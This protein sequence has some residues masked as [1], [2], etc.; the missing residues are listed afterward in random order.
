MITVKELQLNILPSFTEL[1]AGEEGLNREVSWVVVSRPRPPAFEALKGGEIALVSL[2]SLRLLDE[3]IDLARL[4]TYL[5]EM[6][7]VAVAVL[8]N[9]GPEAISVADELSLPVFSLPEGTSLSELNSNISR[10]IADNRQQLQQWNQEVYRQFTELAIEGKGIAAIAEKLCQLTGKEVI[11]ED[12][13]FR[14]RAHYAPAVVDAS[15]IRSRSNLNSLGGLSSRLDRSDNRSYS[16]GNGKFA[17]SNGSAES[18]TATV[19]LSLENEESNKSNFNSVLREKVGSL[20]DWLHNKELRSS[21]PPLHVFDVANGL[22]QLVAPIIVQSEVSGYVSLLGRDFTMPQRVAISRAAAALAIERAREIAVSA[23][24]DR[25]QANVIDELLD[26]NFSNAESVVERAKRL[27]Y[28]LELPYYVVAFAFR[29]ET[30]RTR[31]KPMPIIVGGQ[32][33]ELEPPINESMSRELQRLVEQEAN[34]R[35]ITTITRVR[36]DRFVLLFSTG[37]LI[38]QTEVKKTARIFFDR[39]AA[40]FNDMSVTAGL[41]RYYEEADGISKMAAEAEKA[42]TMGL[43][44]FGPGQ[45]TFFGDLGVYRLLLTLGNTKELREFYNEVLGRLLEHDSKNGGELLQTLEC[46]FKCH[47][48]PTEMAEKMHLHRNTLLYRLRRI[49]EILGVKLQDE[50]NQ[51]ASSETRLALHLALRIGEVLGERH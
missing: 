25:L 9:I 34:R 4:F 50:E 12:A 30:N 19:D 38:S 22:N 41:G 36:D 2:R 49:E 24:E 29:S 5:D 23:V 3:E 17:V 37:K 21:D 42:V 31:K 18:K 43:R 26:G 7:V 27:G 1:L 35:Q 32:T 6:G 33:L 8:G 11:V 14:V 13:N 44:L 47:G 48:S 28:N 15:P 16:N 40:H 39:F 46:Y 51:E 20:R 10:Y 45:L